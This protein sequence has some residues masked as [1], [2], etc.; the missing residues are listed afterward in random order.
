MK[1]TSKYLYYFAI[2]FIVL[3]L[4]FR[5]GLSTFLEQE[6]FNLVLWIALSY[7]ILL[8]IAGWIFG[9]AHGINTLQFDI[10]IT[11]H[12]TGF[13]AWSLTSLIWFW[14]GLNSSFESI[15]SVY[16]AM[17]IWGVFLAI[18]F[19]VFLYLRKSSI[20]GIHRSDIFD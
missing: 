15:Q 20:K 7:G 19:I 6:R 18:H 4:L 13:L 12:I 8:F 1:L 14:L 3:T 17:A 11:F 10:G 2:S 5:F 16:Q 9:R